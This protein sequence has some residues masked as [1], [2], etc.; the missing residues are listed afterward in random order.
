MNAEMA[1]PEPIILTSASYDGQSGY[2]EQLGQLAPDVEQLD[3]HVFVVRPGP[4]RNARSIS[5]RSVRSWAN[6]IT[7]R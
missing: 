1:G 6:V 5:S 2:A 7:G 4:V 3:Q